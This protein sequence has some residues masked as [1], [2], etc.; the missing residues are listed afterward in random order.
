[1]QVVKATTSMGH[2]GPLCYRVIKSQGVETSRYWERVNKAQ[3]DI[4]FLCVVAIKEE[5]QQHGVLNSNWSL[6]TEVK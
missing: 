1:M 4:T 5:K 2:K 3:Y 6:L